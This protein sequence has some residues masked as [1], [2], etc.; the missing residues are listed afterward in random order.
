MSDPVAEDWP[1]IRAKMEYER[2]LQAGF[3]G[4][5]RVSPDGCLDRAAWLEGFDEGYRL[6]PKGA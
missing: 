3:A 1:A 2:G 4:Q 6:K 5:S